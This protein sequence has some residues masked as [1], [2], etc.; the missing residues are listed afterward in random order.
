[1]SA[2]IETLH[3]PFIRF[4]RDI[5]QPYSYSRPDRAT[6]NIEGE[7]DFMLHKD[8][9]CLHIE[10]KD[11]NTPISKAQQARHAELAA[12]GCTVH[13]IRDLE[14]AVRLVGAWQGHRSIDVE[15]KRADAKLRKFGRNIF[16]QDK[17]G[18]FR[19]V[20][21]ATPDDITIPSI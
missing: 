16:R 11:K 17:D 1:M 8:G 15:V 13:V 7:A 9:R 4:L 12:A 10:M 14:A 21:L 19:F 3:K 20:R 18:E 5:G 6:G 2:E